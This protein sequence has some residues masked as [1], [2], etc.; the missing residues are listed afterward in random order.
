MPAR[1]TSIGD[2]ASQLKLSPSTVSRALAHNPDVSDAT[3]QRV[4]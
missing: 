3:R 2:I 1:R 4:Q